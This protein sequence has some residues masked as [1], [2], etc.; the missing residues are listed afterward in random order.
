MST[1]IN[2]QYLIVKETAYGETF[3]RLR[4]NCK[5]WQFRQKL[6]WLKM[7]SL[8]DVRRACMQEVLELQER[9]EREVK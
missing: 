2:L 1:L 9:N 7:Y 4:N 5:W 8:S 6:L 3:L